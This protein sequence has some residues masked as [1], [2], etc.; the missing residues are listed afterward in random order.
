MNRLSIAE[1]VR[2]VSALVEGCGINATARMSGISKP[3]ILKLLSDLGTA[4]FAYH[5]AH[6]RGLKSKRVQ[7]D[8]IWSFVGAKMK[9]AKEEKVA[10]GWGDACAFGNLPWPTSAV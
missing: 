4:C 6:V 10:Q 9:N 3:T 2:V 7:C 5:D 1:R 8:E